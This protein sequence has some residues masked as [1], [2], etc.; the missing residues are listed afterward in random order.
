MDK[1]NNHKLVRPVEMAAILQIT[2]RHLARLRSQ[3]LPCLQV[4]ERIFRYNPSE[5]INY[6]NATGWS[7]RHDPIE[8]ESPDL[9]ASPGKE[10]AV[11]ETSVTEPAPAEAQ[12]EVIR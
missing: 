9:E 3:G 12:E 10:T 4:S 11:R 7:R 1:Y 6:L 5:V 8:E 2:P